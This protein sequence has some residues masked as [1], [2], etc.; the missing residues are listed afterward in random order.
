MEGL[1]RGCLGSTNKVMAIGS[2]YAV[3]V[4]RI[5]LGPRKGRAWVWGVGVEG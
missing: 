1:R 4:R 2:L 3:G 5:G